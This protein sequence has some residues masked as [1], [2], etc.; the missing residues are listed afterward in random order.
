MGENHEQYGNL[1]YSSP[2]SRFG[3]L[4]QT[5]TATLP[6]SEHGVQLDDD[7]LLVWGDLA[8]LEIRTEVIDPP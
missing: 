1:L 4:V 7:R 6:V 3:L 5:K 2:D 8:S